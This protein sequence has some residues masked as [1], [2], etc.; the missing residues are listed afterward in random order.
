MEHKYAQ[1]ILALGSNSRN[2]SQNLNDIMNCCVELPRK[3]LR[4]LQFRAIKST[5]VCLLFGYEGVQWISFA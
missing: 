3:K 2:L 1:Q 5:V 4:A